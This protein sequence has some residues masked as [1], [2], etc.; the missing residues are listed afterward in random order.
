MNGDKKANKVQARQNTV[1]YK[2]DI[3][4]GVAKQTRYSQKAIADILDAAMKEIQHRV[5]KGSR[6]AFPGFG[7]FYVQQR[8]ES[9]ARNFKTQEIMQVPAVKIPK[10]RAGSIFKRAV[11]GTK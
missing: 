7:T 10:F 8:G 2:R 11:R 9:T 1:V 3:V 6:V 4:K 5:R